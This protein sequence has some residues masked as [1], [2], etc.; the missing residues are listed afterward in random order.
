VTR[1]PRSVALA[2]GLLAAAVIALVLTVTVWFWFVVPVPFL[3]AGAYAAWLG[4]GPDRF[5]DALDDRAG[6]PPV[7]PF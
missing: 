6:G 4:M 2:V 1:S 7:A 5:F 3:A